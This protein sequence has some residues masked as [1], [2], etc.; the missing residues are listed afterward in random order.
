M[1]L[2]VLKSEEK[3]IGEAKK[4]WAAV[5]PPILCMVTEELLPI[6][7]PWLIYRIAVILKTQLYVTTDRLYGKT[8]VFRTKH[9]SCHLE[10]LES[11]S[12]VKGIFG[13]IFNYGSISIR[14][15]GIEYRFKYIQDPQRFCAVIEKQ[16]KRVIDDTGTGSEHL[17]TALETGPKE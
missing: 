16:K 17:E 3:R 7:L 6:G 14:T 8:G 15:G 9:L 1:T 2:H 10:Q 12:F 13:R 11:V 5:V 4:H